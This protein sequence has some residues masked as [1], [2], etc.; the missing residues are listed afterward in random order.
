MYDFALS[1]MVN[2]MYWGFGMSSVGF[3][4]DLFPLFVTMVL[5]GILFVVDELG[6]LR[7]GRGPLIYVSGVWRVA[8]GTRLGRLMWIN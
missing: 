5:L 1:V 4:D 7:G 3:P 2:R 6:P 8:C